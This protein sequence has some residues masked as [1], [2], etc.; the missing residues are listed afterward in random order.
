VLLHFGT[1]SYNSSNAKLLSIFKDIL[2]IELF[3]S[4]HE[5]SANSFCLYA[6]YDTWHYVNV[7]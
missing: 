5:H 4:K 6:A 3:N 7:F 2:K 1:Q